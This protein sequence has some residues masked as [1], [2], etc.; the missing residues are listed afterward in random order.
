M[1]KPRITRKF[2]SFWIVEFSPTPHFL[3]DY[4]RSRLSMIRAP[5]YPVI[6]EYHGLKSWNDA[7]LYLKERYESKDIAGV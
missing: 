5:S 3:A 6:M 2:E 4:L 1:S 7:C